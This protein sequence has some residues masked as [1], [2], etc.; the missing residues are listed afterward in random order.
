[1][2]GGGFR[3][4][5][6]FVAYLDRW[7]LQPTSFSNIRRATC[8]PKNN[9][10]PPH[11]NTRSTTTQRTLTIVTAIYTRIPNA[12]LYCTVRSTVWRM[13]VWMFLC[14]GQEQRDNGRQQRSSA[15]ETPKNLKVVGCKYGF[16]LT[17]VTLAPA[18]SSACT[19]C[20][21]PFWHAQCSG[22]YLSNGLRSW[23]EDSILN[24]LLTTGT[25]YQLLILIALWIVKYQWSITVLNVLGFKVCWYKS[26][27]N[28]N[29]QYRLPYHNNTRYSV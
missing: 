21:C 10:H 5:H 6:G 9:N 25:R 11:Y 3:V 2:W 23:Y 27:N 7:E 29:D 19:R 16:V 28:I 26:L 22:V 20:V 4:T 18:A 13:I 8:S 24:A 1:M 15:A 12:Q 17:T 14:F